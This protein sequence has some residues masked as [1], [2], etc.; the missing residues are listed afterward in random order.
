V[1]VMD[2]MTN[3]LQAT[4]NRVDGLTSTLERMQNKCTDAETEAAQEKEKNAA[5]EAKLAALASEAGASSSELQD[6]LRGYEAQIQ[7]LETEV[8]ALKD[9]LTCS[10]DDAA[11]AA[12]FH[13]Q[14]EKD[15]RDK[16]DALE[17]ENSR[18]KRDMMNGESNM[19]Q[20]MSE[21][22]A[23]LA[24]AKA[25][26][27]ELN[28]EIQDKHYKLLEHDQ[29]ALARQKELDALNKII[30]EA[31]EKQ[32]KLKADNANPGTTLLNS[33]ANSQ[34]NK[35]QGMHLQRTM[36]SPWRRSN[37]SRFTERLEVER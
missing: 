37:C 18:M 5:L 25:K 22:E 8:V 35:R 3:E 19:G 15:L 13:A 36:N 12:A 16:I 14:V 30:Q 32:R 9:K 29:Q 24:A 1:K 7:S 17:T 10:D 2:E 11:K 26:I 34:R 23:E 6:K 33:T 20:R 27:E 4:Q 28:A 21:L 31:E